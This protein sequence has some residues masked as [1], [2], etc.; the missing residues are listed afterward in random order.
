[1]ADFFAKQEFSRG[2][3][4]ACI[5]YIA[6]RNSAAVMAGENIFFSLAGPVGDYT[7]AH[8]VI[9]RGVFSLYYSI[10]LKEEQSCDGQVGGGGGHCIF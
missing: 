8:T 10:L 6:G 2:F 9:F 7:E 4:Y 5:I 3:L 1:L